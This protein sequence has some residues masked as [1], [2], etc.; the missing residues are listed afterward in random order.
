M[1]DPFQSPLRRY[2]RAKKHIDN[3]DKKIVKFFK[4]QPYSRTI[5]DDID[6]INKTHKIKLT[7]QIPIAFTDLAVEAIEGLRSTLDQATFAAC[8]SA[9]QS[10]P[11]NTYF[12]ISDSPSELDNVIKGRCK[13]IPSDIITLCRSFN[14]YKGGNDL[15]FALN[16]LCNVNKHR[17]II[18]VGLANAGTHYKHLV[19]SGGISIPNPVWDR[20][21]NEI[22]FAKTAP[23][24]KLQYDIN[25][26][27]FIAFGES[28]IVEG[29]PVVP[30]L[31]NIAKEVLKIVL[32]IQSASKHNK[33]V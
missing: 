24:T 31:R 2:S 18:P 11:R 19:A 29:Q 26:S 17:L 9:G 5:E 30:I 13:D 20:G 25:F 23:D 4:K 15:I 12:P 14:T 32:A 22:I 6:G 8:I 16:R 33:I 3:L 10:N 7:K 27:F 21:K 28:D 1:I